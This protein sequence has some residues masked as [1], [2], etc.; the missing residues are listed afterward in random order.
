M[1]PTAACGMKPSPVRRIVLVVKIAGIQAPFAL[2]PN[3]FHCRQRGSVLFGWVIVRFFSLRV[4]AQNH[5]P[6]HCQAGACL[7][8][9]RVECL[10]EP[11][12]TRRASVFQ[13]RVAQPVKKQQVYKKH[14]TPGR[15]RGTWTGPAFLSGFPAARGRP[16]PRCRGSVIVLKDATARRCSS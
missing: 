12:R 10:A 6:W 4:P 2:F 15:G 14:N 16:A 5:P 9:I 1:L 3:V 8:V 13:T 7:L 11:S